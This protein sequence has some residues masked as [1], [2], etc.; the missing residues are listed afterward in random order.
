MAVIATKYRGTTTYLRVYAELVQAAQ[1]RGLTTYQDIA[2]I[3][4]LPLRGAYMG[5]EVGHILG[6]VSEDECNAGRPMLSSVAVGVKGSPGPGYISC[7]KL[8]GRVGAGETD[9]AFWERERMA[10]YQA[11]RRPLPSSKQP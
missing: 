3:M 8:L 2:L 9:E 10:T 6:E 1:Y 5:N 4:H 7:A 11:W